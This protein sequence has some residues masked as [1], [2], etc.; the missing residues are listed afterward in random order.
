MRDV[1][2]RRALALAIDRDLIVETLWGGRTK[3]PSGHQWEQYGDMFLDGV[4]WTYDPAKARELVKASSY[5]GEELVYPVVNNYYTNEVATAEI[6]V[7]MWADI[8]VNVRMEVKENWKQV[9]ATPPDIRNWSNSMPFPDPVAGL[10]RL[11]RPAYVSR[12]GWNWNP[13]GWAEGGAV[14]DESTDPAARKKAWGDILAI[15]MER[16]PG[17]TMLYQN[18]VFYGKKKNVDWRAYPAQ[19]MDV[20]PYGLPSVTR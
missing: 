13:P 17:G 12:Q 8:G 9:N 2:L 3:V 20:G 4:E 14:L 10:W 5:K 18:A 19:Y 11:W 1:N 6:L 15:W 16:D 7:A